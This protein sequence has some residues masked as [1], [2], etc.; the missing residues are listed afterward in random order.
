MPSAIGGPRGQDLSRRTV[1]RLAI[2]GLFVGSLL[3]VSAISYDNTISPRGIVIHHSSVMPAIIQLGPN[4]TDSLPL[5]LDSWDQ[6]HRIR[7]F[8]VFYWG[9][10]YHLGYH[11]MIFPDGTVKQGRPEHC[12]GAHAKGFNSFLGIALIGDFST[13]S[14]P[15]GDKAQAKPT[16]AQMHALVLLCQ[17][18]RERYNIPLSRIIRHSD[19]SLTHCPG[20]RFP[21]DEFLK[22]IG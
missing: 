12:V 6:F 8:S 7:G 5:D 22:Q 20:D 3:I 9:R 17:R 2:G 16:P 15:T 11:F 4:A 18:L 10:V 19:V 14:N 21:F 1:A 13:K